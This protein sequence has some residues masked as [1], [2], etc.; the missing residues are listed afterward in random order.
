MIVGEMGALLGWI[1]GVESFSNLGSVQAQ[2][3]GM[4]SRVGIIVPG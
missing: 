4:F 3:F 1:I 2:C